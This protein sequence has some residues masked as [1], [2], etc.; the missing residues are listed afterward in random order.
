KEADVFCDSF[1]ISFDQIGYTAAFLHL[2]GVVGA[3]FLK[4]SGAGRDLHHMDWVSSLQGR[5]NTDVTRVV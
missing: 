3:I 5:E 2:S 1:T 4:L